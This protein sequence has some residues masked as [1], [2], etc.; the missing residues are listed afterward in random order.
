MLQPGQRNMHLE[1]RRQENRS[2]HRL[3]PSHQLRSV[4]ACNRTALELT[5]IYCPGP[6][7]TPSG[8]PDGGHYALRA[9]ESTTGWFPTTRSLG[10]AQEPAYGCRIFPF[11]AWR[12]TFQLSLTDSAQAAAA[13]KLL[14]DALI[15]F[16]DVLLPLLDKCSIE[17]DS[18]KWPFIR[19]LRL[20]RTPTALTDA[21][22]TSRGRTNC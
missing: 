10:Q 13:D 2:F 1:Y 6:R 5:K 22:L 16:S 11:A 9:R 7:R 20:C 4:Q 12:F 3:V 15:N 8:N 14:Q 17:P 19:T 21:V 18:R